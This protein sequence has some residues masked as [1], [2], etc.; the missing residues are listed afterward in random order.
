MTSNGQVR[1]GI[2]APDKQTILRGELVGR[3]ARYREE[4]A[5]VEQRRRDREQQD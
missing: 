1:I 3:Y 4:A 2:N 5:K